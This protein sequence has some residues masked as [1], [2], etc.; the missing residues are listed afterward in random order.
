MAWGVS[1]RIGPAQAAWSE[2]VQ[3]RI[4]VTSGML[5]NMKAVQMLGMTDILEKAITELRELELRTSERFRALLIWQIL[6]GKGCCY[7][8][9]HGV[10]HYIRKRY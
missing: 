10:T 3:K 6:L 5:G 1:N 9:S 8:Q 4:A 2:C 7:M